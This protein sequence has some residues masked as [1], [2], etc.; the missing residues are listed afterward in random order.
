[1]T[2]GVPASYKSFDTVDQSAHVALGRPWLGHEVQ[3]G[4]VFYVAGEGQAGIG[5]RLCAWE[6]ANG[7]APEDSMFYLYPGTLDLRNPEWVKHVMQA[8]HRFEPD[9]VV[10]DTLARVMA[11]GDENSV[12]DVGQVL[13]VADRIRE[14]IGAAVDVIH[15]ARKDGT[16]YR[17]STVLLGNADTVIQVSRPADLRSTLTCEKQKDAPEFEPF[18]VELKQFTVA[19]ATPEHK[20]ST[21][22][23]VVRRESEPTSQVRQHNESLEGMKVRIRTTL[24][25]QPG[26]STRALRVKVKGDKDNFADALAEMVEAGEVIRERKGSGF[27]HYLRAQ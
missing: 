7:G 4:R 5:R 22:L 13:S 14:D 27:A 9:L 2:W 25:E 16:T 23:A 19:D 21:S 20:A 12:K 26:V 8:M 24:L 10:L 3:Q 11:G 18:T 15:H 1:M 17:G 6:L